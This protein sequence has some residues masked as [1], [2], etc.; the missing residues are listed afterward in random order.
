MRLWYFLS[1]ANSFF[2]RAWPAIQWSE[3]SDFRLDPSSTSILHL[4]DQRRLWR[5]CTVAYAISI[6]ISC[7]GS[8][9]EGAHQNRLV[10]AILVSTHNIC[11]YGKLWKIIPKLSSNTLLI[12]CTEVKSTCT[13]QTSLL[14]FR[15]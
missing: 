10:E 2:K 6:I 4:C 7:A 8:Y 5:D 9:V 3:M 14:H 15:S 1:S 13:T 11:F 12:C